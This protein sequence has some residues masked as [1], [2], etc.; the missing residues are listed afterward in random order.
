MPFL[1]EQQWKIGLLTGP[2]GRHDLME[3][4]IVPGVLRPAAGA[5]AVITPPVAGR[6]PPPPGGGF[7]RVGEHVEAGRV[8]AVVE[9]PLSGPQ[10]V[11]FLAN[12]AQIRTL[13][14]EL[15]T[16]L[17]D[18]ETEIRKAEMDLEHARKVL[19]AGEEPRLQQC[20]RPESARRGRAR[21][22]DRRG[23][24]SGQAPAQGAL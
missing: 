5:E 3:R 21:L 18:M 12:Q 23:R 1:K 7:P 6:L 24:A 16:R 19:R 8:V 17:M 14:T 9:P 15:Q 20:G 4:L 13:Q 11:Q 10:G 22:P 2:V